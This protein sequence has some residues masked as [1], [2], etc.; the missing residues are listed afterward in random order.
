MA[1]DAELDSR[2]PPTG[3]ALI[4][5]LRR[6]SA[7]AFAGKA[8][9]LTATV[10]SGALTTR[11]LSPDEV[12]TYF[13]AT[14]LAGVAAAA[15]LVGLNGIIVRFIAQALAK[16]NLARARAAVQQSLT[17][18]GG[19]IAVVAIAL[20]LGGADAIARPL[21]GSLAVAHAMPWI[22]ALVAVTALRTLV[23]ESFR[24]F[25]DVL[26]ATILADTL[27]AVALAAALAVMWAA[28]GGTSVEA[29]LAAA[30]AA[31]AVA[32]LPGFLGLEHRVR[33]LPTGGAIAAGEILGAAWPI[34][35][36]GLMWLAINQLD[37][38]ILAGVAPA[39]DVS[40][41]GA[42]AKLS[43]ILSVPLIVLNAVVPSYIA[44]LYARGEKTILERMLR[45]VATATTG[46]TLV[47]LLIF[48]VAGQTIM[49]KLFGNFYG[50]GSTILV[51]LAF[52]D[53]VFAATGSCALAL[54][55]TGYQAAAARITVVCGIATLSLGGVAA[56]VYGAVG[57]A[58]TMSAGIA[59]MNVLLVLEAKRKVG[60]WTHVSL[61][62]VVI[63]DAVRALRS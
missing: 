28:I 8:L 32:L 34:L 6:I 13:V 61:S 29:V 9:A 22:A 46:P 4:A 11:I 49:E 23:A 25:H 3:A 38:L 39:H 27:P 18:A 56:A 51:V 60:V 12:A 40:L 16:G 43:A 44:D 10:V 42:A 19:I 7:Y 1:A 5:R 14:S 59:L 63:A 53:L 41:Y 2:R 15:A 54:S 37:V 21:F 62:P 30:V 52:G 57:L 33:K 31:G 36:G 45:T 48:V 20:G 58:A 47:G 26:G 50:Q 17:Y 24:G 35:L 55:M